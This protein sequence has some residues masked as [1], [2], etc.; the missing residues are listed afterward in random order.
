VAEV[1]DLAGYIERTVK[2]R[3]SQVEREQFSS[4]AWA[5]V[6][7]VANRIGCDLSDPLVQIGFRAGAQWA[8]DLQERHERDMLA[9]LRGQTGL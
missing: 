9:A 2:T 3:K 5:H 4:W 1:I 7:D 8:L 6:E